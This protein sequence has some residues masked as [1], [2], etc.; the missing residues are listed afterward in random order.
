MQQR[1]VAVFRDGEYKMLQHP[2][3]VSRVWR[4]QLS[5]CAPELMTQTAHYATTE[6]SVPTAIPSVRKERNIPGDHRHWANG[7]IDAHHKTEVTNANR[8][9]S[10]RGAHDSLAPGVS[11]S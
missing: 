2:R 4:N 5:S 7:A 1:E 8:Q 10:K 3:F 6:R 11:L 9:G